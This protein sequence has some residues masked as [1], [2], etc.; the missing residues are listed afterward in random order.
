MHS[1]KDLV[2][3]HFFPKS[4]RFLQIPKGQ[5]TC[6][7]WKN[8]HVFQRLPRDRINIPGSGLPGQVSESISFLTAQTSSRPGSALRKTPGSPCLRYLY[9]FRR[10]QHQR[11]QSLPSPLRWARNGEL[12]DTKAGCWRDAGGGKSIISDQHTVHGQFWLYLLASK[13]EDA[14]LHFVGHTKGEARLMKLFRR[15]LT[16]RGMHPTRYCTTKHLDLPAG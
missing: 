3:V 13:K 6:A 9:F 1:Y 12:V 4:I 16:I 2:K 14:T 7:I 5:Q 8:T 10:N 15:Y 11:E